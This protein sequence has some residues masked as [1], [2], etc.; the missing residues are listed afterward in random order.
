[1]TVAALV[2]TGLATVGASGA[3]EFVKELFHFKPGG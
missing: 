1:M 2:A 3:A